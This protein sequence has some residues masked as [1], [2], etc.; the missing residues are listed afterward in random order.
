LD[1]K[2]SLR[3]H[4]WLIT[5]LLIISGCAKIEAPGGGPEDKSLPDI[6]RVKPPAG[7]TDVPLDSDIEIVF[8][9]N[10]N[11]A[12]TE[13]AL[14][15][16]PLYF[17]YPE[18][19]WS[20]KKLR[21]K[22]PG[23][24]KVNTTYV[25]TVGASAVDK[26]GNKLGQ[27]VSFPFSTGHTIYTGSVYGR[28]MVES[29]RNMN[30]WAYK[31]ESAE[32]DTFWKTL[33]DYITQPDSL[34]EFKF[35][36][37]SYGTY[38]V[39][40]VEDNNN[41]QFWAPPSEKLALPD[42]L[43]ILNEDRLEYG[44]LVIMTV[45]RDTL[46]PEISGVVS[47]DNRTVR[48]DFSRR[49]DTLSALSG[50]NYR[51]YAV[52]DSTMFITIDN[53]YPVSEQMQAVF[54]DCFGLIADEKFKIE[55]FGLKSFYNVVSDTMSR[56]FNSGGIDT[57]APELISLDPSPSSRPLPVGFEITVWFSE[58]MDSSG[59]TQNI[60]LT[61]TTEIQVSFH[62]FWK[63]PNK[64]I[65]KPEFVD[66][67]AYILS[68]DERNILDKSFNPL[69][70]TLK[71][72]R[73]YTSSADTFGQVTGRVIS[74]P[75]PEIIVIAR[76]T[77]GEDMTVRCGSEGLF[78]FNRLFPGTYRLRAYYDVNS[79]GLFDGGNIRPFKF[80]EPIALYGDTVQVRSR[81]ETDVG[82][83]DFKPSSN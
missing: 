26:R 9:K 7:S 54:L 45:D 66:D 8:S 18:Y 43:I 64:L 16:S 53:I 47:P 22:L 15:I 2:Y 72:Y 41:D 4:F 46:Q 19:K 52:G 68:F 24:L 65:I 27:S 31:L 75:G 81:W 77:R 38:L 32:P 69:G 55:A 3:H 11:E 83:L 48:V 44:P 10:M 71:T 17:N 60:T 78:E 35:E 56:V 82:I 14:F 5:I 1:L 40:A 58:A 29:S 23:N 13:K 59:L 79:N 42:T 73:Y 70:D 28:V 6:I 25:L 20:G 76:P 51:I 33:P 63:Y 80:A 37:L 21:V 74:A 39:V 36:Y 57:T 30:I 34:G 67:E 61:D 62:A 12:V 50:D 49:M